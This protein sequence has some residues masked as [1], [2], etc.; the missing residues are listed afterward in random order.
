MSIMPKSRTR[1]TKPKKKKTVSTTPK[2]QSFEKIIK[3]IHE[4]EMLG[5][6]VVWDEKIKG[7]QFDVTI[8]FKQGFYD[9]VTLIECRDWASPIKATHV[10]A[11]VTKSRDKHANKAII[12]CPN[13]YQSGAKDVASRHGI[14]LFTLKQVEQMPDD[15]FTS[16]FL[17]FVVIKPVGFRTN[18]EWVF[19]YSEEFE[20]LRYQME[21]IRFTGYSDLKITDLLR[22]FTQLV[23]PVPLPNIPNVDENGMF[24]RAT[25]TPQQGAW[26]MMDN[27]LL[28]I[29]GSEPQI[30]VVDFCFLYWE[31]R[32]VLPQR[33][34][35]DES[36]YVTPPNIQ[37]EYKNVL[38]DETFIIDPATLAGSNDTELVA[39]KFFT[40]PTLKEFYYYCDGVNDEKATM[41]LL[42]SV[43]HGKLVRM[44]LSVNVST[45]GDYLE[46]TD[47]KGLLKVKKLLKEFL[48]FRVNNQ[49]QKLGSGDDIWITEID[50]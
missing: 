18:G 50:S 42:H 13:G 1:T 46:L 37:Y 39:G 21:N 32:A 22:P 10:E 47:R 12:V 20:T 49:P 25:L 33:L 17:S 2:W 26:K 43:Q 24:K 34:I 31:Q 16:V 5:A 7:R 36:V 45:S 44:Q 38:N 3:K 15:L 19:Q 14:E 30:R 23:S 41:F 40:Q 8:R 11:F 9:Y 29:P 4:A 48:E 28:L 27:T 35:V 6:E